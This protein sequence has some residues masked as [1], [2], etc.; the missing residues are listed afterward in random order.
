[1][2]GSE[3]SRS[4]FADGIPPLGAPAEDDSV[5]LDSRHGEAG[6]GKMSQT[7]GTVRASSV[8]LL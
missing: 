7:R 8:N 6:I 1:V 4:L 5:P 3:Q 2:C